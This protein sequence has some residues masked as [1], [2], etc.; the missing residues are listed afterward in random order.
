MGKRCCVYQ[1]F[2]KIF[3]MLAVTEDDHDNIRCNSDR[4]NG[5]CFR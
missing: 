5:G 2:N 1:Y 4:H 3:M